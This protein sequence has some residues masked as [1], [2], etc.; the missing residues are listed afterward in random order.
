[1]TLGLDR[2]GNDRQHG[3]C[4]SH[5][6]F[7]R[8]LALYSNA[9]L[10]SIRP[11]IVG[12][13]SNASGAV[14][15]SDGFVFPPFAVVERGESLVEWRNRAEPDFLMALTVLVRAAELLRRLHSAGI[16]HNNVAPAH[17]LWRP[18]AHA[19]ALVGL[20]CA[21]RIGAYRA[22]GL[23]LSSHVLS[24]PILP[25]H[26]LPCPVLSGA[27]GLLPVTADLELSR[28]ALWIQRPAVMHRQSRAD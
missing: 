21:A 12:V 6:H 1:L 17:V 20:G 7:R 5:A 10:R 13:E 18:N 2:I 19:W 16:A 14:R 11:T 24:C 9:K 4:R 28:G 26:V 15:A 23:M 27:L 3:V 8:E 25:C 22:S